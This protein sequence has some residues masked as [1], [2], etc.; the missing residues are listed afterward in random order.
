VGT[1]AVT[2]ATSY[3]G[4]FIAQRLVAAGRHVVD[5]T[6]APEAAHPLGESAS[7][8]SLDF[9]HPDRLARTLDG[10]DT[11]YNTFWIRFERPGSSVLQCVMSS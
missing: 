7:S 11:L 4:R 1:D 3:T 8:A 2:G 10:V 6:R 5:L 9:D